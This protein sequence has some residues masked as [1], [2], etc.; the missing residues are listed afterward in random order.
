[1]KRFGIALMVKSSNRLNCEN[2]Q[3][4]QGTQMRHFWFKTYKY[5]NM[6]VRS[7]TNNVNYEYVNVH[8]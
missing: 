4:L 3:C 8:H 7:R 5:F 6:E 2:D 1:M